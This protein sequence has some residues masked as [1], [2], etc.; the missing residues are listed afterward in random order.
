R[1]PLGENASLWGNQIERP[2]GAVRDD[3]SHYAAC[4]CRGGGDATVFS[5]DRES[6]IMQSA[7]LGASPHSVFEKIIVCM[8]RAD[9][10]GDGNRGYNAV[11]RTIA[12]NDAILVDGCSPIAVR[13]IVNTHVRPQADVLN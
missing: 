7:S 4:S 1:P 2:V 10:A 5:I 8:D 3:R 12:N 11:G 13:L 9:A 6:R